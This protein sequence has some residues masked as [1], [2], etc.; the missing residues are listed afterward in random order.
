MKIITRYISKE[1]LKLFAITFLA[2]VMLY[3]LVDFF[4]KIDDFVE[5][6]TTEYALTYFIYKVPFVSVQMAPM[7]VLMST[8]ITL[9]IF[10]RK[11]EIIAM[12]A[13]GISLLRIGSPFIA[14]AL[15]ITIIGFATS[16]FIVPYANRKANTIWRSHV[17]KKPHELI[18]KSEQ[19]WYKGENAIYNIRS[20]NSRTNTLEGVIINQFDRDFRLVRRIQAHSAI[21]EKDHW[22]FHNGIVKKADEN[23]SYKIITFKDKIFDL[24]ETPD[25]FKRE[26]KYSD[27]M[28]FAELS[29]YA[30]KIINEGYDA[31]RYLVDMHIKI[32]FPFICVIMSLIGIP[33]ALRKE[34]GVGIATGIGISLGIILLYLV[35]CV[36]AQT[37]GYSGVVPPIV[38]AWFA[39]ILFGTIGLF[40]LV[41]TKQ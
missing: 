8:I 39:N 4:E 13:N 19:L 24:I 6:K 22:S 3:M 35:T 17:K 36:I 21:W 33:L 18:Y 20:F 16:E 28:G 11:H 27:E 15:I 26:V 12:K 10:S 14:V 30:K 31:C 2:F 40:L 41:N 29:E 9:G 32:S 37:I 23:G 25:D 38:A 7:A 34:K 5:T 1:F